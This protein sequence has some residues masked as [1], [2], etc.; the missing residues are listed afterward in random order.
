MFRDYIASEKNKAVPFNKL[1]N[2]KVL[3][4]KNINIR[5]IIHPE[6]RLNTTKEIDMQIRKHITEIEIGNVC[7]RWDEKLFN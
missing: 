7:K 1:L 2:I 4:K 6:T 5:F 3:N